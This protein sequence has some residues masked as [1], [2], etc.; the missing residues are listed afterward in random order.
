VLWGDERKPLSGIAH[1]LGSAA[2]ALAL[3]VPFAAIARPE[4]AGATR[5]VKSAWDPKPA[6]ETARATQAVG[7]AAG[8]AGENAAA[9]RDRARGLA[10]SGD[11][12]G[13]LNAYRRAAALSAQRE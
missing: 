1:S 8:A 13:A 11:V 7:G 3:L 2:L 5:Y 4:S 6:T 10:A 9:L 12:N